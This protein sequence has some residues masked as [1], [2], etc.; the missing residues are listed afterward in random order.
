VSGAGHL[1]DHVWAR[2]PEFAD[3]AVGSLHRFALVIIFVL[4]FHCETWL[5]FGEFSDFFP[6]V[7]LCQDGT[8]CEVLVALS[9]PLILLN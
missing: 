6:F 3:A 4:G 1:A 7:T 2:R 9:S 8:N 5:F